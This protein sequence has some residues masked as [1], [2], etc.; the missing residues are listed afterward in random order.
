MYDFPAPPSFIEYRPID[1]IDAAKCDSII[2]KYSQGIYRST[3]TYHPKYIQENMVGN[4]YSFLTLIGMMSV[5][6]DGEGSIT[7]VYLP[8]CNLPCMNDHES[9][10]I[11]ETVAQINEYF[12][13]SRK[14]FDVPINIDVSDFR[15][16]VLLSIMEIPYGETRTYAQIAKAAGSPNAFR[17]VGTAC[18]ENPV[19]III[20]C[21]RVVPS[22]GGLGNYSGGNS[23]KRKLLDHE[24]NSRYFIL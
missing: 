22:S 10:V 15:Q 16:E 13:G 23:M 8:N 5:S 1:G 11:S 6:D 14:Y 7:G 9:D 2:E 24:K 4:I 18:A 20:P 19:P 12:N 21:H 17:A 3:K